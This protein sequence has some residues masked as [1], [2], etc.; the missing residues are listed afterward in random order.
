MTMW[1]ARPGAVQIQSGSLV[2][3]GVG[4]TNTWGK[5]AEAGTRAGK[6]GSRRAEEQKRE[7]R[8]DARGVAE[9]RGRAVQRE[10]THLIL[11][12]GAGV[13]VVAAVAVLLRSGEAAGPV[14]ELCWWER[15]GTKRLPRLKGRKGAATTHPREVRHQQCRVEDEPDGVVDRGILR[16]ARGEYARQSTAEGP[17]A[18]L[19]IYADSPRIARVSDMTWRDRTKTGLCRK[20]GA[21]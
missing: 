9:R 8:V 3:S 6:C 5:A 19:S 13:A 2:V 20:G 15:S 10:S 12:E 7:E 11:V 16:K 1:R 21:T 18:V 17:V 4:G 14:R